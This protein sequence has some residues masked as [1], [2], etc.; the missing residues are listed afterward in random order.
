MVIGWQHLMQILK[1]LTK[2]IERKM[3]YYLVLKVLELKVKTLDNADYILR[4]N[5]NE[6]IESLNISNTVTVVC[7]HIFQSTNN[8]NLYIVFSKIYL[9][10]P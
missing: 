10:R 2:T 1:D 9:K 6:S 7:H 8:L 5:M 4:V 3:F